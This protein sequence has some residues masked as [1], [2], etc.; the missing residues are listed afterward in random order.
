MTNRSMQ[1]SLSV[2]W[3]A[4]RK[5]GHRLCVWSRQIGASSSRHTIL[6]SAGD[7]LGIRRRIT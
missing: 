6:A 7:G 2:A 3:R 1:F 5:S 4:I